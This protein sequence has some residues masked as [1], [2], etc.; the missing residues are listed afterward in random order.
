MPAGAGAP[1]VQLTWMD[2]R[3]GNWVVTP[4]RGKPVEVNA[5]WISGL[6]F[7]ADAARRLGRDAADFQR[8]LKLASAG[9]A[10]F[11]NA[12]RGCCFDVLDGPDG[13]EDL[14]RPNQI[15]AARAA[16]GVLPPEQARQVLDI[17]EAHLLTPCGLRSLAPQEPG[18][19]PAYGGDQTQRDAAYHQGTVWAWLIGPFIEAHLD[20]HAD[21]DRAA[22]L[23]APLA[24]QLRIGG[25]GTIGEIF[26]AEHPFAPRGCIAQAWSVA[27]VLRAWKL[28]ETRRNGVSR[29]A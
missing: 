6:R 7:M 22:A 13:H 28:I 8:L 9:F 1:G 29:P 15:L 2:A 5:L 18:Y 27:E 11:W 21:P 4:R 25:L 16:A 23:L 20:L 26:E 10:R 3:V 19:Q 24:D 17:C 14:L 12:E